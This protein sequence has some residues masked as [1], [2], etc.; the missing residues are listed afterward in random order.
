MS[1]HLAPSRGAARSGGFQLLS[2]NVRF[3]SFMSQRLL[4]LLPFLALLLLPSLL[5]PG[6]LPG[7]RVVAADDHLAVHHVFRQGDGQGGQVNNPELSDPA[8]QFRALRD[9]VRRSWSQGHVPLWNPDIHCGVPLLADAQSAAFN[10]LILLELLLPA[11]M[12]WD[13]RI[14]LILVGAGLGVAF[15]ASSLGAGT[16]GTCLAG[17]VGMLSAFP[18]GWLLHPHSMA[19]AWTPWLAWAL[20]RLGRGGGFLPVALCMAGLLT[21]GHPETAMHGLLFALGVAAMELRSLS[22]W[23]GAAL[24][25]GL[26]ALLAAPAMLPFAQAL[27]EST[28]L[29]AHGGNS[30]PAWSLTTLVLPDPFGHPARGTWSMNGSHMETNLH[31]GMLAMVLALSS[32]RKPRGRWLL[33]MAV[34]ALAVALG[35]PL[36]AWLP[37]NHSRLG[38]MAGLALALAAG[39]GTPRG[40][41]GAVGKEAAENSRLGPRRGAPGASRAGLYWILGVEGVLKYVEAHDVQQG[42]AQQRMAHRSGPELSWRRLSWILTALVALELLWAR[43]SDQVPIDASDFRPQ[44]AAWA[45]KLSSLAGEGRVAGLGWAIQPNTAALAGM[46]DLRGYDLPVSPGTEAIMRAMD[47][48]LLRPWFPIQA[49]D[50]GNLSALKMA[51][52]RY[53]A[54]VEADQVAM[55][56]VSGLEAVEGLNAPLL[57]FPLDPQAPRAWL[58]FALSVATPSPGGGRPATPSSYDR[59]RP[60]VLL[61][62]THGQDLDQR[63]R[64]RLSSLLAAPKSGIRPLEVDELRPERL[65]IRVDTD[66]NAVLVL[67]DSFAPGW[68]ARLDGEDVSILRVEPGF[69]AVLLGPGR[70]ELLFAYQPW[71][72]TW[73]A[74]LGLAGLVILVLVGIRSFVART[75]VRRRGEAV[76][77]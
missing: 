2:A 73:G 16:A 75:S 18:V 65:V 37:G 47:R 50:Q 57:L 17:V 23:R 62:G 71:G 26:G 21:A 29:A 61:P 69:R 12:A 67:A 59:S 70:H 49:L 66:R 63:E 46:R 77:G 56:S 19:Y 25:F 15:L 6:A 10:P 1:R 32:L 36:L 14:W 60:V 58:A 22:T 9:R 76:S 52:V 74:R 55:D 8:L 72:W 42:P 45:V 7:S 53:L 31:V 64:S 33:S 48:R 28:T 34:L 41:L 44:P 20:V 11:D 3:P 5:F 51:A 4:H 27:L 39:L 35:L 13:L 54:V 24:G 30:L 38:A 43:R 40:R 68:R